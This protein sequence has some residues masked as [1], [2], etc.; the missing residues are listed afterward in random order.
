MSESAI[1]PD[2]EAV[3]E[4]AKAETAREKFERERLSRRQALKKFGMTSAMATFAL[5]S[6]DDLARMV[7]QAMQ[8]R[9][10]DSKVA[11]QIAHEFQNSGVALADYEGYCGY[12]PGCKDASRCNPKKLSWLYCPPCYVR[13]C[14]G[15]E[16]FNC[17]K[18]DL[19]ACLQCCDNAN[20]SCGKVTGYNCNT[21]LHG[22]ITH[23]GG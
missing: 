12:L 6:V 3:P 23:C 14:V 7:G 18:G 5:F 20:T 10:G 2:G 11:E 17:K 1:I 4:A 15:T 13:S 16:A 21:L 8:K 9:A 22:C 19:N